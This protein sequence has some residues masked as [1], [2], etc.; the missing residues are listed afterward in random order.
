MNYF[1]WVLYCSNY[2]SCN[3]AMKSSNSYATFYL[4][5]LVHFISRNPAR[6]KFDVVFKYV[7]LCYW[8]NSSN[9]KYLLFLI[10]ILCEFA[11]M[12]TV[13]S[14]CKVQ[15]L[16]CRHMKVYILQVGGR[17]EYLTSYYYITINNRVLTSG[18]ATRIIFVIS[19]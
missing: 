14:T 7:V 5:F 2:G 13:F 8:A 1:G 18:K 19:T 15:A 6:L 17:P 11:V 3:Y 16:K 9:Q 12:H 4:V 10:Y